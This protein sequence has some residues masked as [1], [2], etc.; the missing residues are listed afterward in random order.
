[1]P[2]S[3]T[4]GAVHFLCVSKL[5]IC[6]LLTIN[7]QLVVVHSVRLCDDSVNQIAEAECR[8]LYTRRHRHRV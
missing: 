1:M 6:V 5:I 3:H 2:G 4:Q 8:L 7:G